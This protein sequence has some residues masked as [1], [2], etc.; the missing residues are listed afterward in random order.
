M[1]AT[2]S[3]LSCKASLNSMKR[4]ATTTTTATSQIQ[5]HSQLH[6]SAFISESTTTTSSVTDTMHLH[7]SPSSSSSSSTTSSASTS[8]TH[9]I[10]PSFARSMRAFLMNHPYAQIVK[11]DLSLLAAFSSVFGF[12]LAGGSIFELMSL[13]GSAMLTGT[14]S[15]AFAASILNQ[16][17]ET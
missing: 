10:S 4:I 8:N 17:I 16:I 3:S 11:L 13:K 14:I 2:S 15:C 12:Y 1:N 5:P 9:P 7:Q 6:T